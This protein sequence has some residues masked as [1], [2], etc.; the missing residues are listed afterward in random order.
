M[1]RPETKIERETKILCNKQI[2]ENQCIGLNGEFLKPF[3]AICGVKT[4]H[5]RLKPY[6]NP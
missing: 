4:E 6:R 2:H 1:H 3:C 5:S